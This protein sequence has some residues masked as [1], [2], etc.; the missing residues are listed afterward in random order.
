MA[1]AAH[2][3]LPL[4][5]ITTGS[6]RTQHVVE[7]HIEELLGAGI[8]QVALVTMPGATSLVA[9]LLA[10]F[11]SSIVLIEQAEPLGF[12]HAILCAEGWVGRQPFVT[13]V[14]DHI[15]VTY[16]NPSCTHQLLEI[17]VREEC[18]VSG[19]QATNESELP[20]FGV[21]GGRR[22]KGSDDLYEVSKV[23]EK[24][25]PTVAEE[26][27]VVAGVRR[28][29]YLAFFGVHA[30]TPAIFDQLREYQST[31]SAGATLGV[32]ESLALLA[33]REKY[34]AL[35]MRGHRVDLEGR[36]GLLRAQLALAMH[37]PHRDEILRLILEEVAE[38]QRV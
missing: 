22:V 4:Q 17:A 19:V 30:L 31:L 16:P 9:Q 12:G 33:A 1:G 13:Q 36:F 8:E 23:L 21:V 18:S 5:L 24:P 15:F 25:T 20:Y 2:R 26:H 32:T 11:G 37:G 35:E 28:G 29:K 38:A 6:G 27:C 10:R 34:L 3:D 7:L 14:C